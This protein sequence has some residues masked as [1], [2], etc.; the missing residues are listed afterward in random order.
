MATPKAEAGSA[1]AIAEVIEN[2]GLE[3]EEV[4]MSRECFSKADAA[5]AGEPK[6]LLEEVGQAELSEG[7][8]VSIHKEFDRNQSGG[9]SFDQFLM[10]YCMTPLRKILYLEHRMEV[11]GIGTRTEMTEQRKTAAEKGEG[12]AVP[13]EAV[14]AFLRSKI[15]EAS[16][17]LQLP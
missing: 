12:G 6:G 5:G 8:F 2:L 13:E 15:E 14:C 16:A 11:V 17:C 9:L 4:S 10:A 1:K 7:D 3:A